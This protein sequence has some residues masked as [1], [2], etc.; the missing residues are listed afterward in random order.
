M[1]VES[2]AS[3]LDP[4]RAYDSAT[5]P[6]VRVIYRGLVD[7]DEK[8]GIVNEVA[9]GHRVSPD[10][11]TYTFQLRPG[12]LF[13][14]DE[15]TG[16]SPGRRVVAEDFRYAIERVLDPATASDGLALTGYTGLVGAPEFSAACEKSL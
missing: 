3:T 4:A 1:A 15:K 16:A 14:R 6:F 2:D 11:K 9:R 7:Y 5:I 8:A 12:V 13:H 10:G